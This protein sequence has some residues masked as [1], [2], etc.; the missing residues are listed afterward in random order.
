MSNLF[1]YLALI[2]LF[3]FPFFWMIAGTIFAIICIAQGRKIKKALFSLLLTFAAFVMAIGAAWTGSIFGRGKIETCLLEARGFAESLAAVIGCGV[4]EFLL[5]ALFWL[6]MLIMIG[7]LLLALCRAE[8][9]SWMS[10]EPEEKEA[11]LTFDN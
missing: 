5:A 11:K 10:D 9:Q 8:N 4:L 2:S 1:G 6:A 3:W 7:F